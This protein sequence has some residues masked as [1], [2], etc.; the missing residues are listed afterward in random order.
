M[1]EQA[2][3]ELVDFLGFEFWRSGIPDSGSPR[4]QHYDIA[5]SIGEFV[6]GVANLVLDE[7]GVAR[8]LPEDE[9]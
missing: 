1:D 9:R 5:R 6:R 8:A 3:D 4:Q 7:R 2:Y